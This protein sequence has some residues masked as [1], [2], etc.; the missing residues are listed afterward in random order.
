MRANVLYIFGNGLSR[1]PINPSKLNGY[2][3]GCNRFYREY[4]QADKVFCA[5]LPITR[6]ILQNNYKGTVIYRYDMFRRYTAKELE[7]M[8][9]RDNWRPFYPEQ[10]IEKLKKGSYSSGA[11][12]VT[13]A[14]HV[15]PLERKKEWDAIYLLGFDFFNMAGR[16][17]ATPANAGHMYAGQPF[18]ERAVYK[19]TGADF[20]LQIEQFKDKFIRVVNKDVVKVPNWNEMTIE[21]FMCKH[22]L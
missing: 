12:A 8:N 3:Y 18:Y 2:I 19:R 21:E 17:D 10:V 1:K 14:V 4:P 20:I 11:R 15:D 5:D 6:E 9:L 7:S 13:Y 16:K 22:Q